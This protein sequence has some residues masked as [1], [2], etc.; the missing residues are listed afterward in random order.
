MSDRIMRR[1][2]PVVLLLAT[3]SSS[4]WAAD[5][6]SVGDQRGN[7]RAILEA[8]GE[9]NNTPYTLQW[10]E[11]ANAAPL[12]EAMRAGSIDA[13]AVGDA[14][15]T[16]A[17]AAGLDAKGILATRYAGN[18][19]IVKKGSS[20]HSVKDLA[21]KRIATV[22]GSSGHNLAL[23]ALQKAGLGAEQVNFVFTTPAEATLVLD[24]GGVNAVA[25]W[26]PYVSF[27]THQSGAQILADG[28]D[29]PALGYLV[30]SNSALASK[31]AELA[32]FVSRLTRARAWGEKHPEAYAT[33]ISKLLRIPQEVALAKVKR[34]GNTVD[35]DT[36]EVLAVQQ[37]TADFYLRNRLI[38]RP[39]KAESFIDLSLSEEK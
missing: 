1:F 30:A 27:A 9:L 26:E 5:T 38:P 13:G 11:F 16:F 17:V 2:T 14:P 25:T 19:I 34:E 22:K 12:L 29:Y 36:Q 37:N 35:T 15:L 32:D 3:F 23:Q 20:L 21:G 8:A 33:A 24:Q 4:L 10:H 18:A 6:L 31:K 7:A 28:K 39:L